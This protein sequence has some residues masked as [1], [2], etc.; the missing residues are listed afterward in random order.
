MIVHES[1]YILVFGIAALACFGSLRRVY[2]FEDTDIR[3]GLVGL[4]VFS[5]LWAAAQVGR[6]LTPSVELAVSLYIIGLTAGLASVGAWLYFSS[7]YAGYDYHHN[8]LLRQSAL[9]FYITVI[10]IKFTN[11]IHHQYFTAVR[12]E[13]PYPHLVIQRLSLYWAITG[14]SYVLAAV[15]LY[16]LYEAVRSSRYGTTMLGLL[17]SL[18]AVPAGLTVA[19]GLWPSVLLELNYEPLGVAAFAIGV[20]YF[21]EEQFLAVPT[22]ARQ[23]VIDDLSEPVVIIDRDGVIR[24]YNPAAA[25]AFPTLDERESRELAGVAPHLLTSS[26]PTEPLEIAQN[27]HTR[28]YLREKSKITVGDTVLGKAFVFTDVT[29]VERQ[30]RELH[31]Q[32]EQLEDFATA[33]THELRNTLMVIQGQIDIAATGL[34]GD[35][36]PT[37]IEALET[38]ERTA[39]RMTRVVSD[40]T[41]LARHGQTLGDVSDCQFQA[42]VEQAWMEANIDE[43]TLQPEGS[44]TIEADCGR[45]AALLTETFQFAEVTG[46]TTVTVT[47]NDEELMITTNGEPIPANR[48]EEA[49]EYGAA[50]PSADVGMTLPNVRTLARVHGWHVSIDESYDEGVRIAVEGMTT[51]RT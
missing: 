14:L 13:T 39:D 22:F 16:M 2:R 19:S 33:I 43:L 38:V 18:A 15:G 32:N 23:Q 26:D 40:L 36:D 37:V 41:R 3:R 4:L 7:A 20:L 21:V 1:G 47:L 35:A 30:R 28:Y 8:T 51:D 31:R 27:D 44:G 45:L 25:H 9:G 46:A 24:D 50:V 10:A 11:P 48:T 5:G 49:F 17:M 42:T 29:E 34:S 6:L 12:V